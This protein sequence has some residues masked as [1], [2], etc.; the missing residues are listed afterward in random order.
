MKIKAVRS[1]TTLKKYSSNNAF[2]VVKPEA[3]I[4][5]GL[6]YNRDKENYMAE[7]ENKYQELKARLLEINNIESAG[8]VLMWDQ[9]TY[10]P[11][12]GGE[13]R[14]RQIATLTHIAR[15]KLVDKA[16]G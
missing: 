12:G 15:E 8:G 2:F 1:L 11:P 10:M 4:N 13:A 9:A 16:G 6:F 5:N 3:R 7:M 14:G